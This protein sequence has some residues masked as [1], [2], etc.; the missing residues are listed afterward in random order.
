MDWVLLILVLFFA[1]LGFFRGLLSQAVG[2]VGVLV[3]VWIGAVIAQWVGA[4]WTG[5]Q[6][7]VVFL[8][9]RWLVVVLGALAIATLFGVL[10]EAAAGAIRGTPLGWLDRGCGVATGALIGGVVV[11]LLLLVTLNIPGL[12]WLM[13]PAAEA[14][15]TRPIVRTG[16][17]VCGDVPRF[18]GARL[19][20]G[21]LLAAE[22]RLNQSATSI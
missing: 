8:A 5:A 16:A 2:A 10:G 1:V 6:P 19:L 22:R 7:A 17:S 18:P 21:R 9:L 4:R 13:R 11:C 20:R 14:R 15:F 3:A 12:P